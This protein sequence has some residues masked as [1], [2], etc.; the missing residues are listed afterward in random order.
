MKKQIDEIMELD[1]KRSQEWVHWKDVQFY[2]AMGVNSIND[3]PFKQAAPEMVSIINTQSVMLAEMAESLGHISK[4]DFAGAGSLAKQ[5]LQKYNE[6]QQ[7]VGGM[8]ASDYT[9]IIEDAARAIA[10]AR[11]LREEEGVVCVATY[12]NESWQFYTDEAK[13]ALSAANLPALLEENRKLREELEARDWQPLPQPPTSEEKRIDEIEIN[14]IELQGVTCALFKHEGI[15]VGSIY[16]RAA[17]YIRISQAQL[18]ER[19]AALIAAADLLKQVEVLP[20]GELPQIGDEVEGLSV[21]TI[22]DIQGDTVFGE[23][24]HGC[25]QMD[26]SKVKIAKRAGRPVLTVGEV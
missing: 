14:F 5:A 20:V 1:K 18:A 7:K 15:V 17:D 25:W 13:A 16:G 22:Y 26:I 8:M 10:S 24:A 11:I 9:K 4:S 6:M 3:E 12:A 2:N 21:G 19:D 23:D